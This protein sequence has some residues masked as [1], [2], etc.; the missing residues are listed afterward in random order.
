MGIHTEEVFHHI[1]SPGLALLRAVDAAQTDAFC[2]LVVQ[3]FE[4]VAVDHADNFGNNGAP[5]DAGSVE[6]WRGHGRGLVDRSR[7]KQEA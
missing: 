1:W 3:D 4:G 5:D 7:R 2:V 6:H